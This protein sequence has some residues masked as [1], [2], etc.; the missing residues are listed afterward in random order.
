MCVACLTVLVLCLVK[1][2]AICL[3]VVNIIMFMI[4][5][6]LAYANVCSATSNW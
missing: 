6:M 2:F 4:M 5:F 3:G 1:Q